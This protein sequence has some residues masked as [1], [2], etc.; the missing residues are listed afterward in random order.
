MWYRKDGHTE[1][2]TMVGSTEDHERTATTSSL[3]IARVRRVDG[4]HDAHAMARW[5]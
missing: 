1:A 5:V 2:K 3:T 4:R